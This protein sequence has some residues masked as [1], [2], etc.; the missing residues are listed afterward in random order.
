MT[1]TVSRLLLGSFLI[2][3]IS[4]LTFRP[5]FNLALYGDD[6]LAFY[7]YLTHLGPGAIENWNHLTYF[8]TPY[9]AQDI[10][11]GSLRK[12]YGFNSVDY[13]TTSYLFRL[14]ASFSLF[15]LVFYFTKSKLATFFS[16]L[17]FSVT[18]IG[19]DTTTWVFNMPTYI[20]VGLFN[21]TLYFFIKSREENHFKQI[22]FAVIL[23]Y[24][25]Y[26]ITPIR[27]HGSLPFIFF[28]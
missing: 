1:K 12:I 14:F 27:M 16:I 11:M 26:I 13:Y 20:T 6:W 9:G 10:L 28:L 4:F 21:L 22:F 24:F 23:Y 5:S 17:F 2:I 18:I 8:L 3:F 15:P 25:A 7:R 19:L